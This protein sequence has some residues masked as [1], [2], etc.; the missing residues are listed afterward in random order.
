M[1]TDFHGT[2]FPEDSPEHQR[3]AKISNQIF[4]YNSDLPE[5]EGKKWLIQVVDKP[6][7]RIP[8]MTNAWASPNGKIFVTSNFLNRINCDE[9]VA[10]IIAEEISHQCLNHP[11]EHP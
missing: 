7:Y 5:I 6:D 4:D 11:A 8:V 9:T 2:I 3:V 10:M 1:L